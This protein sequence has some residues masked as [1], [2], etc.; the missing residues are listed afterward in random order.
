MG[1][2]NMSKIKTLTC[3]FRSGSVQMPDPDPSMKPEQV[4]ELYSANHQHLANA[5]VEGP[6]TQGDYMVYE[7]VPAPVKTK[8]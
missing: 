8:G 7:F 5:V 4:K 2:L 6:S 3:I 1:E